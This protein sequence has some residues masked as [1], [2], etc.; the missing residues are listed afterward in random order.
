MEENW[1]MLLR[2]QYAKKKKKKQR[3]SK[4]LIENFEQFI[5]K[6]GFMSHG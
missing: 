2:C 3:V 4:V 1:Q 6:F 5:A